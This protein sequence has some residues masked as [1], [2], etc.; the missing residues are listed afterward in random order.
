MFPVVCLCPGDRWPCFPSVAVT[1][2]HRETGLS[3]RS[4]G[5]EYTGPSPAVTPWQGQ[6][7]WKTLLAGVWW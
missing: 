5:L 4:Q 6:L 3:S 2:E 7:G 1:Q